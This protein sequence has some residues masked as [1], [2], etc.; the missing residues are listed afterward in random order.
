MENII[1]DDQIF[2]IRK[3]V[4]TQTCD[5]ITSELFFEYYDSLETNNELS[6]FFFI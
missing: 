4:K 5:I 6:F 3:N 1:I 2:E